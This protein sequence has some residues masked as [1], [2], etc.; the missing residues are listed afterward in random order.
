MQ[1][2]EAVSKLEVTPEIRAMFVK[3]LSHNIPKTKK[4][5]KNG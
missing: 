5:N 3:S 4:E 2:I 1:F